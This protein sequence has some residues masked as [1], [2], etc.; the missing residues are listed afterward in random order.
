MINFKKNITVGV[1]VSSERGLEVAQIDFAT[2]TILK[3]A[4]RQ[5]SFDNNRKEISDLDIFKETLQD[6]YN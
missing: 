4:S 1:S 5:L 3:Y 6:V 2:K